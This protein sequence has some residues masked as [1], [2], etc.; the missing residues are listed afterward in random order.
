MDLLQQCGTKKSWLLPCEPYQTVG[1]PGLHPKKAMLSIWWDCRGPIYYEL[2]PMN[3]TINSEKYCS[4]LDILKAAI[5]EK[6]TGLANRLRVVFHQDNAR[7]HVSV[8][9]MLKLKGFGWDILNHPPILPTLP[10]RIT[11]CSGRWNTPFVERISS[12]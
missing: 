11:I 2:L 12:I 8:K 5:E 10:L 3:E 7:P 6:R 4:Q 9:T 1:K